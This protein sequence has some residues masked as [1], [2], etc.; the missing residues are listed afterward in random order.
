MGHLSLGQ[1][2]STY[3]GLINICLEANR[4]ELLQETTT[5][6]YEGH[7]FFFTPHGNKNKQITR[8]TMQKDQVRNIAFATIHCFATKVMQS[9][10]R[11][12]AGII[13][14]QGSVATSAEGIRGRQS[15]RVRLHGAVSAA[16][17]LPVETLLWSDGP[18]PPAGSLYVAS[19]EN[20][21]CAFGDF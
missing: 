7:T 20:W 13:P 6:S 21:R 9:D 4:R 15:G 3:F 2:K 8:I 5:S 19:G 16:A 1:V 14:T 11:H 12:G 17:R 18:A 10:V